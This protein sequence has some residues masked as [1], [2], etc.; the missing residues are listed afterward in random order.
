LEHKGLPILAFESIVDWR[1]WLA[2]NA[3]ASPGAWLKFARRGSGAVSVG[4]AE[5]IE[6]AIAHGWIDGQINPLDERAWLVRFT[7]RSPKSRWS[8]ISRTTAERLIDGGQMQPAGLAAVE[9]ARADGRW[10]AA[11]PSQS[12]A[13][14]PDDL[15]AA[16]DGDAGA[17]SFF[18][19][20][21]SANR[22]AVLYRVHHANSGAARI[23]M[24]SKLVAMLTRGEAIHPIKGKGRG[25]KPVRG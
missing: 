16:L 13:S 21:D 6:A 15:Q 24:I 7:P 4:K 20:L 12:G 8:Q 25:D 22:Y 10:A 18:A 19:S 1:E 2:G 5:A 17:K 9:A 14:M 3:A 23:G 11:Y